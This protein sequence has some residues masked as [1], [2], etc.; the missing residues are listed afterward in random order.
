[1]NLIHPKAGRFR[2]VA[3]RAHYLASVFPSKRSLKEKVNVK[4]ESCG[5]EVSKVLT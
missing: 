5:R 3:Q 1:M 4:L 2:N